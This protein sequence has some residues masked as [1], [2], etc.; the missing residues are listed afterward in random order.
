MKV[1]VGYTGGYIEKEIEIDDAFTPCADISF[2]NEQLFDAFIKEVFK[3]FNRSVD[4]YNNICC[5]LNENYEYLA[6]F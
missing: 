1:I 5:I 4:S 3:K 6:E 2:E